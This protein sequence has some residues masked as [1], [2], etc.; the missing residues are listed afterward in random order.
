[1]RRIIFFVIIAVFVGIL[2][3]FTTY[4]VNIGQRA[5]VFRFGKI[6][7]IHSEGGLKFKLPFD[8]LIRISPNQVRRL[9]VGYRSD[10][11]KRTFSDRNTS[12]QLWEMKHV[13]IRKKI[14]ESLI[15]T[16]DENI[17]D[18]NCVLHYQISDLKN[19]LI[20]LDNP[21]QFIRNVTESSLENLLGKEKLEN[22]LVENK[23]TLQN[24][25]KSAIQNLLDKYNT[26]ISIVK[27]NLQD[28]H[29]PVEVVHSFRDVT[30]AREDKNT[31]VYEALEY[32]EKRIPESRGKAYKMKTDALA[33]KKNA[34]MKSQGIL[35]RF[36]KV[37]SIYSKW[38][39]LLKIKK[40]YDYMSSTYSSSRLYIVS[41][42][43]LKDIELF[44]QQKRTS[45]ED[46]ES[47]Y[48]DETSISH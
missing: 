22:I 17:V 1:M 29:P 4:S 20:N 14:S 26:G 32:R 42:K 37:K 33:E 24:N 9:E 15:I 47:Y 31:M 3:Y 10:L 34:I 45:V 48:K 6:I 39:Q 23:F 11:S 30:S 19:Y 41:K 21:R 43:L 18:V 13:S 25:L 44:K 28:I 38:G 8:M 7:S 5:V 36:N 40:Y 12:P 46:N 16:S 27:V 2:G 35:A